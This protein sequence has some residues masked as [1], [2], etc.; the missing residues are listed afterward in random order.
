[1]NRIK[2]LNVLISALCKELDEL[3]ITKSQLLIDDD[4]DYQDNLELGWH[5]KELQS[6]LD[7]LELERVVLWRVQQ[8][9][10]RNECELNGLECQS[11]E[12]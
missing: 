2:E 7:T 12:S 3:P 9:D 10:L 11:N 6:R 1:M 5:K 8:D 4:D